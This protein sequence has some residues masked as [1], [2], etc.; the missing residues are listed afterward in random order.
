MLHQVSLRKKHNPKMRTV[1]IPRSGFGGDQQTRTNWKL[2]SRQ[3]GL[4][5]MNVMVRTR[6]SQNNTFIAAYCGKAVNG[7]HNYDH[8][9]LV[10][11]DS[12]IV[13]E[14]GGIHYMIFNCQPKRLSPCLFACMV[15]VVRLP[16]F[17]QVAQWHLSRTTAAARGTQAPYEAKGWLACHG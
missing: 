13:C 6:P 17:E 2:E 9:N 7:S 1:T 15:P 11:K 5:W 3:Q 4:R 12:T 14:C 10:T 8:I 16:L